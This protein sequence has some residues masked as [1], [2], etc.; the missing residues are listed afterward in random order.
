MAESWNYYFEPCHAALSTGATVPI[1][2]GHGIVTIDVESASEL[3]FFPARQVSYTLVPG[4]LS[5]LER[6]GLATRYGRVR[7]EARH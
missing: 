3:V 6:Q 2:A 5:L 1:Q 4:F 7:D